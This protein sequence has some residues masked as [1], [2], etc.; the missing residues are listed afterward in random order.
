MELKNN[1]ILGIIIIEL[2]LTIAALMSTLSGK[3]FWNY[4][5][6]YNILFFTFIKFENWRNK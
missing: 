3:T 5:I 6:I 4:I 2:M 1:K